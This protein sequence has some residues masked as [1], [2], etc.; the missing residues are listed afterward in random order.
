MRAAN[1]DA[2]CR[3]NS[4]RALL[5]GL[6]EGGQK[7]WLSDLEEHLDNA[8]SN[9]A[10]PEAPWHW[11]YEIRD[12]LIELRNEYLRLDKPEP[13]ELH[14]LRRCLALFN[15][16]PRMRTGA[17]DSYTLAKNIGAFLRRSEKDGE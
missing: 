7:R 2:I 10:G 11:D 1:H 3:P 13:E 17:D 4:R 14:L 6:R 9:W 15:A 5:R 16:K 8:C 12:Q